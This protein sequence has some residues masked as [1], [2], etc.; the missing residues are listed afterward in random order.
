MTVGQEE[1]I[2]MPRLT[3]A[4]LRAHKFFILLALAAPMAV[5]QG[6]GEQVDPYPLRRADTSGPRAILRSFLDNSEAAL[7]EWRADPGGRA[8]VR[9]FLIAAQTL[10]FSTTP[11]SNS[12]LVRTSADNY[13]GRGHAARAKG[14]RPYDACH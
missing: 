13:D 12:Y 1:S 11:H 2:S 14:A 4:F 3:K 6:T 9:P 8:K 7:E 10:D 5:A